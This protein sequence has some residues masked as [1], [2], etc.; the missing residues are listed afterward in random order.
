MFLQTKIFLEMSQHLSTFGEN[1]LSKTKAMRLT[2]ITER[3]ASPN[4]VVLSP[5]L[6][7]EKWPVLGNCV[8]QRVRVVVK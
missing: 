2:K 5:N 3:V 7:I 4:F 6:E 1:L 8:V